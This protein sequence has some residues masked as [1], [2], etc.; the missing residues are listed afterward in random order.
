VGEVVE[1][2]GMSELLPRFD[3]NASK[4]AERVAARI[5]EWTAPVVAW[6]IQEGYIA[7]WPPAVTPQ[8]RRHLNRHNSLQRIPLSLTREVP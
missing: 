6:L 2:S 3:R 7:S 8:G 5:C 1:R 4:E